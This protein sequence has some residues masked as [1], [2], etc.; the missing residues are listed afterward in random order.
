MPDSVLARLGAVSEG[1]ERSAR[2]IAE[3]FASKSPRGVYAAIKKAWPGIKTKVVREGIV[4]AFLQGIH[5][6]GLKIALMG[7]ED[8][9]VE[10]RKNSA[11]RVVY[12]LGLPQSFTTE[13]VKAYVSARKNQTLAQARENR[14]TEIVRTL[15]SANPD[16]IPDLLD[17]ADTL[18]RNQPLREAA[19]KAGLFDAV[20][21]HLVGDR[22]KPEDQQAILNSLRSFEVPESLLRDMLADTQA[23]SKAAQK[24]QSAALN[25]L[26]NK[27]YRPAYVSLK[28]QLPREVLSPASGGYAFGI[29][30]DLAAFGE[31]ELIPLMIGVIAADNNYE[32]VY[33]VGY[34]GLGSLTGVPYDSTHDGEW[35]KLWWATHKNKLP[36]SVRALPIPEFSRSPK[37]KAPLSR[38]VHADRKRFRDVLIDRYLKELEQGRLS[39]AETLARLGG[40]A[41]IPT[42]IGLIASDNTYNS[43]Y[44]IGYFGL[45]ILTGVPYSPLHDGNWWK[46]W[47]EAHKGELPESVR[48]LPLPEFP[49]SRSFR[50]PIPV[51]LHSAPD[52]LREKLIADLRAVLAAHPEDPLSPGGNMASG[53]VD[54]KDPRAIPEVIEMMPEGDGKHSQTLYLLD[55]Y[56]LRELTGVSYVKNRG[57][58][59]WGPW[60]QEN[61]AAVE[62]R[63]P[64]GPPVPDYKTAAYRP[65]SRTEPVMVADCGYA[66]RVKPVKSDTT[67]TVAV[68]EDPED[69]ADVPSVRQF[70]GGDKNK[71]YRLVGFD[72]KRTVPKEGYSLLLVLPGGDGSEQFRWFIRRIKKNA[73]PKNMLVAQLVAPQWNEWQA[74]NL[75]WPTRKSPFAGMKFSTEEFI[76]ATIA[77]VKR[78]TRID[79]KRVYTMAWSSSGPAVYTHLATKGSSVAGA[80]IAMSVFRPN[81][82]PDPKRLAGKR[83]YLYHSPQDF[84]K[85]QQAQ[86]AATF[87]KSHGTSVHLEQYEGGHGWRGDTFGAIQNAID[88]LQSSAP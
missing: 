87:L 79:P 4:N 58:E 66:P 52:K 36:E 50:E 23:K 68:D 59:W 84:I 9:D 27:R 34:F 63:Y 67:A 1:D 17:T 76:E 88:F 18:W 31:P 74:K 22:V 37:Y 5:P 12:T 14:V 85:I 56:I 20:R 33:G 43:V 83:V 35:W 16:D 47:W 10:L 60:W 39:D 78:Q 51:E 32:S 55:Y 49:R 77:D 64:T 8:S 42:M 62:K 54:L 3:E 65:S 24:I 53:L 40:A 15:R 48:T 61:K 19:R 21:P 29:A 57:R 82:I 44:N 45:G 75:V 2:E 11:R 46:L 70:A 73:L 28:E 69:I 72:A 25:F 41:E 80:F 71:L 7:L 38:E 13:Q 81:E 26:A 6:D 30:D 86:D